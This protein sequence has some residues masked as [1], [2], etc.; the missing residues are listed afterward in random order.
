[1]LIPICSFA[2][3]TLSEVT[4]SL[5]AILNQAKAGDAK[6]QNTVG[7]W[8]YSGKHVNQDYTEA[9]QWWARSAQQ[10]NVL[11]IGNL[12]MCYQTG[13]GVKRD[14]L[15]AAGLYIRS[16]K[17]G[18]TA[19]LAQNRQLADNGTLFNCVFTAY[20][21]KE[22][23]GITVDKAAAADYYA[24]AAN[25]GSKESQLQAGLLY[26]NL[27]DAG[28]AL[29]MFKMGADRG[30]LTCTYYY[31]RLVYEGKGTAQDVQLGFDY[32]LTAAEGGLA[33]AQHQVALAYFEGK[34]V[35][36]S[37]DQGIIWLTKAAN[38]DIAA[39]QYELARRYVSGD[40]VDADYD[41]AAL[42][43]AVT[44]PQGYGRSFKDSFDSGKGDNYYGTA[45]HAYLKGLRYY[46]DKDFDRALEQFKAVAKAG[47]KEGN[48]MQGV[49]LCNKDYAKAN[50]KK[51]V[52]AL[53]NA[54][55]ESAM[56]SYLLGA[57][58]EAGKNVDKD[59][60]EAL[61]Y[62][63][64]AAEAGYTPAMCYLGDMYF[65]GRGVDKSHKQAIEYYTQ[66]QALLTSGAAKRLAS[67]YEN[68]WGGL[69]EDEAKAEA[70]MRKEN[71]TVSELIKL[72]PMN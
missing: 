43:F 52:K 51:G 30:E 70:L 6:A 20:C 55:S 12:G 34:G 4:D 57:M 25:L 23:I 32:M 68:G 64:K 16:I 63:R 72:V 26:L 14:S 49:I 37:A 71:A 67:C 42:W 60:N 65:E 11:A 50:A 45:F 29:P 44:L 59:I 22:G 5:N 21:L 53:Q 66:A 33:A 41:Q 48:T 17:D 61:S 58:Y 40:G 38:Q 19:L 28:K 35:T 2:Q 18:N 24:K 3:Q 10:G 56:A 46:A 9:V 69:E 15:R 8:Y 62:L 36:K 1:M 7:T 31:G 39:A 27:S 54:A 13:H 47:Q